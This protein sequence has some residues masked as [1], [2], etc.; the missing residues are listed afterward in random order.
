MQFLHTKND[1]KINNVKTNYIRRK[2]LRKFCILT[3]L[4][5]I[6]MLQI[7]QE[8]SDVKQ[9]VFLIS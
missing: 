9:E 8:F 1:K 3:I 4:V 2:I 5:F 7:I 6:A